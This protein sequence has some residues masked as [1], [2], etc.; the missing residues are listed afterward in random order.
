MAFRANNNDLQRRM[1]DIR[2]GDS[3][4]GVWFKYLGGQISMTDQN[5]D[6]DQRYNLV[7]VGYDRDVADWTVGLAVDYG[8]VKGDYK[9]GSS[10]VRLGS[11]ALYGIRQQS[12]GSYLDMILRASRVQGDYDVTNGLLDLSGRYQSWGC[13]FS[14]EYGRRI[15]QESGFYIDPSVELTVGHLNGGDYTAQGGGKIGRAHV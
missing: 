7:Q 15:V 4:R 11:L 9:S 10:D 8:K 14:A 1:G 2:L 13:S 3:E 5:V 6:L 12:D